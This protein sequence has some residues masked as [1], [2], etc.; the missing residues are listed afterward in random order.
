MALPFLYTLPVAA[1]L[2]Y[3]AI[4]S[5]V[6]R[7]IS[8]NQIQ[9]ILIKAGIGIRR[10][11]LLNIAARSRAIWRHGDYLRRLKRNQRPS[12]FALPEALT[13][14][15][16]KYSVN[17][18]VSGTSS[19]TGLPTFQHITLAMDSLRTREEMEAQAIRIAEEG[20]ERY[21]MT[22]D[23]AVLEEAVQA[24]PLGVL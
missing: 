19:D 13:K 3:P 14:L 9:R 4:V 16:R 21:E 23:S 22:A 18:V 24:S 2:A 7:G 15:T 12:P 5:G 10:S 8:S 17:V 6:R 1:R 11:T 20:R